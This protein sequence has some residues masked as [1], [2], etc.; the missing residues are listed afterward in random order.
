MAVLWRMLLE[1]DG[2]GLAE[3]A[4]LVSLVALPAI[5]ALQ[6]FGLAVVDLMDT[7]ATAFGEATA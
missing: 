5:A 7:V 3:Y 1:E 2:A 4:F 6:A